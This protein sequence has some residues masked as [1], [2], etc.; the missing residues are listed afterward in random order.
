LTAGA[1]RRRRL[2]TNVAIEVNDGATETAPRPELSQF[3]LPLE[4]HLWAG[5]APN[6]F[7]HFSKSSKSQ[8]MRPPSE[9]TKSQLTNCSQV[10]EK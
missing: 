2:A 8:E 6:F 4:K 7:T 1:R 3:G 10:F 9:R 5:N